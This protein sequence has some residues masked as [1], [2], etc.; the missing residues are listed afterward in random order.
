MFLAVP[1][2]YS[3]GM[4]MV[5]K[6]SG[7]LKAMR[8]ADELEKRDQKEYSNRIKE[9]VCLVESGEFKIQEDDNE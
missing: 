9:F 1:I 2:E 4:T 5:K 3:W 8:E 6:Q 7:F